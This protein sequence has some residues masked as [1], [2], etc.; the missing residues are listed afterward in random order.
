MTLITVL[1]VFL[2]D[3]VKEKSRDGSHGGCMGETQNLR[4]VGRKIQWKRDCGQ[5]GRVR[6]QVL[7]VVVM[8]S[9][10]SY[11]TFRRN[12]SPPSSSLVEKAK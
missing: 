9:V 5:T 8:K 6:V 4:E 11:P 3:T 7:T 2:S 1:V 10:H 12:M